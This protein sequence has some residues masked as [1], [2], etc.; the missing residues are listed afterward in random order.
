MTARGPARLIAATIVVAGAFGGGCSGTADAGAEPEAKA[1]AE[2]KTK[3]KTLEERVWAT[4]STTEALRL[5]VPEFIDTQDSTDAARDV[6]VLWSADHLQ[7]RDVEVA[8]DETTFGLV[9]KDSGAER[10]K[11]ICYAARVMQIAK[12]PDTTGERPIY[13]GTF[14]TRAGK[15]V[16][17]HAIGS[18]GA[19]EEGS[20]ARFCG[21]VTGRNSYANVSGGTTHAISLVGMFDL[22]ENKEPVAAPAVVGAR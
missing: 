4:T 11:R 2:A 9:M 20:R 19:L 7:W 12:V 1:G 13:W 3:P 5:L 15:F 21:F 14:T 22:A 8:K 10:G 18:T 16:Y 17:F 6:F